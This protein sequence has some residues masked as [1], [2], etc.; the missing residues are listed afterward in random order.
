MNISIITNLL[1]ELANQNVNKVSP[2]P[3]ADSIARPRDALALG[4]KVLESVDTGLKNSTQASHVETK[5]VTENA[6]TAPAFTPLPL[7]S[8]VFPGARFYARLDE[9]RAGNP[10]TREKVN[11]KEIFVFL[12]TENMGCIWVSLSSRKDLLSVKCFTDNERSS[13]LL[14]ENFSSIKDDLQ[15]IGFTE[16]TLTSQVRN[17]LGGIEELL[18]KFEACLLNQKV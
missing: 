8:E 5:Q 15:K 16:V 10:V 3:R 6:V 12:I 13:M 17:G 11:V 18:P 1:L 9:E 14:R 2:A 4:K 7:R